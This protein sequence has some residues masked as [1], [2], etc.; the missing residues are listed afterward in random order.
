MAVRSTTSQH[1]PIPPNY[2][3][4]AGPYRNIGRYKA[5]NSATPGPN[6]ANMS[7]APT[8]ANGT[9]YFYSPGLNG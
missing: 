7:T 5:V 6:R 8:L 4:S 2:T 3:T 1:Q 9:Q